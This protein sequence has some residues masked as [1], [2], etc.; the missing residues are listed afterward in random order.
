MEAA[1]CRC[2]VDAR[3][4]LADTT[5]AMPGALAPLGVPGVAPPA[6]LE[7]DLIFGVIRSPADPAAARRAPELI[8]S[9]TGNPLMT[10]LDV[11]FFKRPVFSRSG[12]GRVGRGNP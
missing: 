4:P 1:G 12:A 10:G 8:R 3:E 7:E 11:E 9:S 6:W 5:L 2:A